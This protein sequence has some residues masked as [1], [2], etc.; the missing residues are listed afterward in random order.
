MAVEMPETP[1]PGQRYLLPHSLL[2]EKFRDPDLAGLLRE[3]KGSGDN[4][5]DFALE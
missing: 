2:P 1:A 4:T 5:I 3:V